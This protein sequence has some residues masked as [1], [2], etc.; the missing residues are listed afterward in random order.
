MALALLGCAVA[1]AGCAKKAIAPS[2]RR[3]WTMNPPPPPLAFPAT[4]AEN[5]AV[6][7]LRNVSVE[8]PQRDPEATRL[9]LITLPQA[10]R[11]FT[12]PPTPPPRVTLAAFENTALGEAPGMKP[13]G[14]VESV[15]LAEGERATMAV[16]IAPDGCATFVAQ[17]GLGVVELDMFLT[18]GDPVSPNILAE[19][20]SPGPGA[21]IGGRGDCFRNATQDPLNA[22][23]HV[24]M[25]RGTGI[26][27]ARV[28]EAERASPA[29]TAPITTARAA[30]PATPAA[31][32]AQR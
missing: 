15:T 3:A 22:Q 23:I 14:G 2:P 24:R 31:P 4:P 21:A 27:L 20:R 6:C 29:P 32:A 26:V 17:G 5:P 16:T 8:S 28:Y 7:S 10:S 1:A 25:R 19:D 12:P 30:L 11:T 13:S 18:T 9:F